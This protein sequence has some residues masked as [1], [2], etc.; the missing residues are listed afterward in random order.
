M[1][2][3]TGYRIN[4]KIGIPHIQIHD[5]DKQKKIL[6]WQTMDRCISIQVDIY[7]EIQTI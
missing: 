7:A 1:C 3:V 2:L 5:L 6:I 4:H